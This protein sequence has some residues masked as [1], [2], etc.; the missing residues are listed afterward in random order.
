MRSSAV[1]PK[2]YVEKVAGD[3]YLLRVDDVRVEFFEAMWEVPERITY[4]AYVLAGD[5]PVLFDG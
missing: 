3:L 2:V 5:E 1:E 4:N